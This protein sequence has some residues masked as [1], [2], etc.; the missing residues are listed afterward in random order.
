ME[1][2]ISQ[3]VSLKAPTMMTSMAATKSCESAIRCGPTHT[4]EVSFGVQITVK[5]FTCKHSCAEPVPPPH[6]LKS[7]DPEKSPKAESIINTSSLQRNFVLQVSKHAGD[8]FFRSSARLT[9]TVRVG[10]PGDIVS[11]ERTFWV[12]LGELSSAWQAGR[13]RV[14]AKNG[15]DIRVGG[16]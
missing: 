13:G 14:C 6:A 8:C 3:E 15:S 16:E 4:V 9:N 11:A 12:H 5:R 2:T 1:S 10:E 7:A